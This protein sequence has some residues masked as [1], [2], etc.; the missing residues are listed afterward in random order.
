[1]GDFSLHTDSSSSNAGQPTGILQ[2]FDRHQCVDFP[3]HIPRHSLDLMICSTGCNVLSISTS[4]LIS[5]HFLLLLTCKFHPTIIGL[6]ISKSYRWSA[7]KPSRPI[8]KILNWLDI[9]QLLQ[10]DWL[11]NITVSSTLSLIIMPCGYQKDLPE[12]SN[13]WMTPDILDSKWHRRYLERVW[14][15][16]PTALNR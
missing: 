9:P 14:H 5:D 8:S 11:N 10:L 16:N 6:S 1:M 13:L 3:T 2:S 4:D 7:L 12:A 15:R